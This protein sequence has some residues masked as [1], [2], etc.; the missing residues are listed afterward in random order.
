MAPFYTDTETLSTAN[1]TAYLETVK[2]PL[3]KKLKIA[4]QSCDSE[5]P[6]QMIVRQNDPEPTNEI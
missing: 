4:D 6:A 5:S 2:V 1:I 3:V